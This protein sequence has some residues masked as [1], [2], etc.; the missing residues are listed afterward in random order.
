[1]R[2]PTLLCAATALSAA[3]P[4]YAADAIKFGPAP[5]WVVPQAI[6]ANAKSTDA[7]IA[8]LLSDQQIALDP[9]KVTFYRHGAMRIQTPQG[10]AAGNISVL[11]DPATEIVTVNKLNIIRGGKVIDV[12]ASGQ[13]FTTLRRETNLD[14]A[15]LDGTLTAAL[16]PED[17]QVGDVIEIATTIERSDPILKNHAQTSFADWNGIPIDS[18][19]AR[20]SWPESMKMSFKEWPGLPEA[21]K[22][23]RDGRVVIELAARDLEPIVPPKDAPL[24]FQISRIAEAA[25]FGSWDQI[26]QLMLPLFQKAAVIPASGPLHDEV[27]KIRAASKDPKIRAEQALALVENRV[28]YV[29]LEMGQGGYV[30]ASAET[31]WSRRFGDCKAKSALLLAILQSLGIQAEPVLV[32]ATAGDAIADDVPML[33]FDHAIVRAHIA[34]KSYWLDGTRTGDTDLDGIQVPDFGWVLPLTTNA[35]LVHLVPPPL[36][37]PSQERH[38]DVDATA[39]LYAPATVSIEEIYRGDR[40]VGL[41]NDYAPMT[42]Q[43][44]DE[45]LHDEAK[46]FFDTFT[47]SSSS[48]QFDQVKRELTLTIKGTARINWKDGWYDVPTSSIAYDPDF[49]RPAGPDHDAP[50]EVNHP[51]FAKDIATIRLPAGVAAKENLSAPVHETL[52][53]IEYE[54]SE[55][56]TGDVLTVESSERSLAP[57]VAYKDAIVAESR[58]RSLSKDDVFLSVP[59]TYSA[60]GKD[61]PA[62]AEQTPTSADDFVNRGNTYL[63]NNKP[64]EAIADFSQALKLEPA[65]KWALADRGLAYVWKHQWDEA[66]KDLTAADAVDKGNP[67]TLRSRALMAELKNDCAKAIDFYT[68]SLVKEPDNTFALAHRATCEIALSRSDAAIA[69]FTAII[70]REPKNAAAFTGR[71]VVE[72]TK[73]DFEA[74]KKDIAAAEAIDPDQKGLAETKSLMA[75]L[76]GDFAEATAIESKQI[77]DNPKDGRLYAA[78]AETYFQTGKSDLAVADTDKA[79]A[80]DYKTPELRLLR[81]N[82][83]KTQGKNDLVAKEADLLVQENPTSDFALTAAAKSYA[84]LG[85]REKA[86][87][88]FDRALAAKPTALVYINRSQVRPTGDLAGQMTD[89]DNALKLEPDNAGALSLKASLLMK[90]EKFADALAL[91]DQMPPGS[92]DQPWMKSQRALLLYKAGRTADSEKTFADLDSAAKTANDFNELCWTKATNNIMLESALKNCQQALKLSPDTGQYLDSLGMAFLRLGRLDEALAAYN[93]AIEKGHLAASYMGRA[94]TYARKGET[95]RAQA[96]FAEAKKLD[97]TI[98]DRFAEYGLKFDHAPVDAKA[99]ASKADAKPAPGNAPEVKKVTVVSVTAN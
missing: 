13:T 85:Q 20:V 43:Q 81:A 17:L 15:T 60:T 24:R 39:G 33:D 9:G 99:A 72:T 25:D 10:L 47:V 30:P 5:S 40:A 7:P 86:M 16:Q 63:N 69:D 94:V 73:R 18:A 88:L 90:Q 52:A 71:A 67:V 65:N 6:P 58:L 54:R 79:L 55:T 14:A 84:A 62:L 59:A 61:L 46:S 74:A 42:Q 3:L 36:E 45:A 75:K 35:A 28:R 78:R 49:D 44:R 12:L 21:H 48:I 82:L 2:L 38:V 68:Q 1:M 29:A 32:H 97:T 89:L 50:F 11:W 64:D 80:L 22:S 83:F 96:D 70:Q 8:V 98:D 41:N 92:A 66:A 26:S 23:V 4:A 77:A 91:Y 34:G 27:E 51:S 37:R 93:Q 76:R 57:E 19:Y 56:V 53:G 31:T 87:Q 95:A